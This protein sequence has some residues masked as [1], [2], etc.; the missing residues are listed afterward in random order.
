VAAQ[1]PGTGAVQAASSDKKERVVIIE[2]F[3]WKVSHLHHAEFIALVRALVEA[4]GHTPR[5]CSYLFGDA[6][7]VTSDL[8]FGSVVD[9]EQ[10]IADLDYTLPEW[11]KFIEKYPDLAETGMTR[12]LLRVH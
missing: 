12:E 7:I 3:T 9:R 11:V 6:G 8:E 5:V 10:A 2:R 1:R 4:M